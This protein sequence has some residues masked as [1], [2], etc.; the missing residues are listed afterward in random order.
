MVYYV[1]HYSLVFSPLILSFVFSGTLFRHLFIFECIG[2]I[3]FSLLLTMH[4]LVRHNK[5]ISHYIKQDLTVAQTKLRN[6]HDCEKDELQNTMT[7]EKLLWE[8]KEKE[9]I[10]IL[11]SENKQKEEK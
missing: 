1:K 9:K 2:I 3:N 11:I 8:T 5:W 7:S 4:C 10:E 6:Q